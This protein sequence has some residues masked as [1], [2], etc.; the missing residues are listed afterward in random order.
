MNTNNARGTPTGSMRMDSPSTSIV[1]PSP[2]IRES[3]TCRPRRSE[4]SVDRAERSGMICVTSPSA[5]RSVRRA[6]PSTTGVPRGA[7]TPGRM[8][9]LASS[10]A[11]QLAQKRAVSSV[12]R[13]PHEGTVDARRPLRNGGLITALEACLLGSFLSVTATGAPGMLSTRPWWTRA[14]AGHE[15]R[16]RLTAACAVPLGWGETPST[17]RAGWHSVDPDG[18]LKWRHMPE[19]LA[20]IARRSVRGNRTTRFAT[21]RTSP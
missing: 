5:S 8:P 9:S 21:E 2:P 12:A 4:M 13:V 16:G 20:K 14:P 11:P 6:T 1:A 18:V 10:P 7:V 3:L 17:F 15:Q 19:C